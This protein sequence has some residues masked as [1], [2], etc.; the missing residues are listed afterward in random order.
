MFGTAYLARLP[1]HHAA[2]H[3]HLTLDLFPQDK[4][5]GDYNLIA[6]E[7]LGLEFL[8]SE[9]SFPPFIGLLHFDHSTPVHPNQRMAPERSRRGRLPR[10]PRATSRAPL[11]C[12]QLSH[13]FTT[14]TRPP[15]RRKYSILQDS[16]PSR[17]SGA[18]RSPRPASS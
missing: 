12:P 7:L 18:K 4:L 3:R 17:S 5:Y 6:L 15:R 10:G 8:K 16:H 1:K 9:S 11:H 13:T 2:P 14:N